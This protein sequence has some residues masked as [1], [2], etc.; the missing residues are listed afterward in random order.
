[1]KIIGFLGSPR[2][3]GNC[4]RLMQAVLDGA[5]HRGA[6]VK[7]YDLI[8]LNIQHCLGCCKCIFDDPA[9]PIGRCPIKDDMAGILEDYIGAEGYV[10]ASPAYHGTVTALMKK[11]IERKFALSRRSPEAVGKIPEARQPANFKKKGALVVTANAPDAFLEVMG[12]PCFELMNSDWMIEQVETVEKLYV[13]GIETISA[14]D[15]KKREETAFAMGVKLVD[16]IKKDK[17]NP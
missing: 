2:V 3:K 16:K 8:K 5:A 6:T 13:G 17:D 10:M 1:L 11:F 9:L 7:R 14:T 12:D 4:S 15:M